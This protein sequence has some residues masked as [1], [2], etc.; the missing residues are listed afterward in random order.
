V[1]VI[2]FLLPYYN[3]DRGSDNLSQNINVFLLLAPTSL[4][5]YTQ[6]RPIIGRADVSHIARSEASSLLNIS[7]GSLPRTFAINARRR[8]AVK[9]FIAYPNSRSPAVS[10]VVILGKKRKGGVISANRRILMKHGHI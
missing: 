5:S 8:Y 7:L 3:E 10:D 6:F 4:S 1:N 9:T 2:T